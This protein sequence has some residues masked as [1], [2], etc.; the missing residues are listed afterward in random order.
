MTVGGEE[1]TYLQDLVYKRSA[2]VLNDSKAYLFESRLM[3][4]ALAHGHRDTGEFVSHLR[5]TR[6]TRL[7]DQVVEAMTTNETLW[8][9]DK[10]PFDAL[11]DQVIPAVIARNGPARQL[12]IWSAASSSG[13]ELY[14]VTILLEEEFPQLEGWRVT[15]IGTDISKEMVDRARIGMYSGMEINRGL[16][17]S[18][19]VRYFTQRG[20]SYQLEERLR[21]KAT[22]LQMNLAASPWPVLPTFDVIFL[23]NVLIYFDIP[24]RQRILSQ[25]C[26]RLVPGGYLFLG[27][28]ETISGLTDEF[29]IV[30][31]GRSVFYRTRER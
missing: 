17:A 5:R 19:L 29:D 14:S 9:R 23:R 6:D 11:R 13:Q 16:P 25:V 12:S 20:T 26:R 4:L 24:T 8:F 10:A 1:C 30:K 27:A 22:F 31:V 15:L 28:A 18:L 21:R 3:P 7:E 2:I